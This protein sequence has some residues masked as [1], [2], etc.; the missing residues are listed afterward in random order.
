LVSNYKESYLTLKRELTS[1]ILAKLSKCLLQVPIPKMFYNNFDMQ[2]T[3]K[4]GIVI[5]IWPLILSA[6]LT[7]AQPWS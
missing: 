6:P 5:E 4:H 1:L 3:A 2:I 7:L